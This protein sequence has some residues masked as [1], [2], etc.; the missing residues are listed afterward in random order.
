MHALAYRRYGEVDALEHLDVP[1]P[2]P[3]RGQLLVEVH[4][5]A[6]NPKD[7]LV[8]KG[9]FAWL[10]GRRFPKIVGLDYAGVVRASRV[11][12]FAE[13]DRV[14]GMLNERTSCRGT[15]AEL[16]CVD[17]DEAAHL[18]SNAPFD[19]GAAIALAGLT[20]L[21][22]LRDVARVVAGTRIWIHG[23]AGG[24]GTLA[25][26]LA[27]LLGA[28]VTTT[29]S[30]A[31]RPLAEE[32][33]AHQ[34]LDRTKP[35]VEALAGAI[36]VVFDVFGNLRLDDVARVFPRG[37]GSYV[38]TIPTLGRAARDLLTRGRRLEERLVIVRSRRRDLDVLADALARG[39]LRAIVD[40]RHSLNDAH[41]AFRRL[42][43]KQARGK[44]VLTVRDP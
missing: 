37:R 10:S 25:V 38:N 13:G 34:A 31:S 44:L 14:F 30:D 35:Y 27:R 22:A 12:G 41:A 9:K 1:A 3:K 7:A 33:G 2:T 26:Q 17:G 32:L 21:Q 6:L 11:T 24:V 42:E 5:A 20:A 16:V 8:R 4:R 18:P 36:D 43:S 39:R 40:A 15:A 29:T 19:D 23:A 28:R